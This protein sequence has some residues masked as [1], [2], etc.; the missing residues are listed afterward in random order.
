MSF[1]LQGFKAYGVR[2]EGA[3]RQHVRQMAELYIVATVNDVALDISNSA[4]TFWTA[5]LADSSYG[6]LASSAL[7]VLTT[8]SGIAVAL[9]SVK[10]EELLVR[11]QAASPSGTSYSLSVSS[12][13]PSITCA[14][15]NGQTSW[16]IQLEWLLP[17]GREA[18]V[19]DLGA[20]F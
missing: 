7:S 1:S 15:G 6:S 20:Q 16:H 11:L 12:H 8:I 17:D 9:R 14:A 10:S 5:A 18:M 3:T 2:A 13:L 19:S 4:G